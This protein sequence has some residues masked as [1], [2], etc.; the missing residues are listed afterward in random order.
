MRFIAATT[1]GWAVSCSPGEAGS[2]G[3]SKEG[4]SRPGP[5]KRLVFVEEEEDGDGGG[6]AYARENEFVFLWVGGGSSG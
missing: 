6:L 2:Y 4:K 1:V 3:A 5:E